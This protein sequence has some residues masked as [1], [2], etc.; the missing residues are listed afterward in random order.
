M[1][2]KEEECPVCGSRG[3]AGVS[4]HRKEIVKYREYV[5]GYN[6]FKKKSR[7]YREYSIFR[8]IDPKVDDLLTDAEIIEETL[9]LA[10][11]NVKGRGIYC[12]E[13]IFVRIA[14]N[15]V[16]TPNDGKTRR[17]YRDENEGL[18][19]DIVG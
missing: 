3:C 2:A 7:E 11:M 1:D 10:K 12:A 4:E 14:P 13:P 8:K 9:S 19:I 15:L 5:F 16:D 17:V 18:K 6:V